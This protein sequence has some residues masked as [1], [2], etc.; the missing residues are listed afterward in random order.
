MTKLIILQFLAVFTFTLSAQKVNTPEA[1]NTCFGA[2]NI[3]ESGEFQLQFTGK[4]GNATLEAYP[5]LAEVSAENQLWCSFIASSSGELTFNASIKHGFVQMV[6]FAEEEN[7][8]CGEIQKGVAEIKRLHIK[9][10][11]TVVGLDYKIGGG[12]L[13]TLKLEK[14]KK[15]SVLFA[16]EEKLKDKLHLDW[17]FTPEVFTEVESK[18]VD[19]RYD[20]FAPTFSI[21]VRDKATNQPLVANLSIEGSKNMDA[22]YIGSDFLFNVDRNCKLTIK[23]DVEGY[24]FEDRIESVSA[25]EDMELIIP[26]E[27]VTSGKSMAIEDIEFT[28][29]TSQF[30]HSAEPKLQRLK[31][32]LALNSDLKVEIQGHVFALGDNSFAGQRISEAR[33]RRVV[34]YL[35]ENGIDNK[36]LKAVGYG[37]TKPVFEKPRFS[38]EEQANRRVEIMVL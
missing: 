36:R 37:N 32:F 21:S 14:G 18:V 5:S 1:M 9:K 10:D 25:S 4:K 7:D 28:P 11:Q 16:T 27:V 13:Y 26:L 15:I 33:A 20:D 3:F 2:V 34:K 12:V 23:C 29:G 19:K 6:V 17:K 35:V 30:V 8:L 24:F 31:D 38:Y 22:L